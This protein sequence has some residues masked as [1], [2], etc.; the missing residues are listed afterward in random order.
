MNNKN[1][2][3]AYIKWWM[4]SGFDAPCPTHLAPLGGTIAE[5]AWWAALEQALKDVEVFVQFGSDAIQEFITQEL[6][7][8][9]K[10]E[11]R[12]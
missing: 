9:E 3:L 12:V 10:M 4:Q 1:I 11:N 8:V 7:K 5:A 6:E 2:A